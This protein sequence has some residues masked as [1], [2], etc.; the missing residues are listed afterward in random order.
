[1]MT[2]PRN[3]ITM[4]AVVLT[5]P[6]AMAQPSG[7][8]SRCTDGSCP[9]DGYSQRD[10]SQRQDGRRSDR[11]PETNRDLDWRRNESYPN[12]TGRTSGYENR[13]Y[14]LRN[15]LVDRYENQ[16]D[17]MR[18]GYDNVAPLDSAVH[19]SFRKPLSYGCL[20]YTSPSPRD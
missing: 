14:D 18:Y 16:R 12:A 6:F 20:L 2:V 15:N 11:F 1:M 19:D 8:N 7:I 4:M 3:L 5:T 10:T 13:G 9:L 17:R